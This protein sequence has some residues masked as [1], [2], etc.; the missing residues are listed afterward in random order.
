MRKLNTILA[1][2]NMSAVD[3]EIIKR[4]LLIA[5]ESHAQLHVIHVIDVAVLDIEISSQCLNE[6]VNEEEVKQNILKRV[7]VFD[8]VQKVELLVHVA[9]GKASEALMYTAKKVEADLIIMGAHTKVALEERFFGS[10]AEK[11]AEKSGR[12]VLILK[13]KVIGD[14]QNVLAPTDLSEAS[15]AAVLFAQQLF[16]GSPMKLL[17]AY[18]EID[19]LTLEFTEHLSASKENCFLGRPHTDIFKQKVKCDE[20]VVLKASVSINE[21]LLKYV[22]ADDSDIIVLGSNGLKVLGS[23]VGSTAGFLLTNTTSDVLIYV[24]INRTEGENS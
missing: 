4:A 1:A 23:Y 16:F 11:V 10:T 12:P 5:K 9:K 22:Q 7:A 15:Q 8:D 6:Q 3:D 19:D 2:V 13:N 18:L 17:H 14:Y 20:M 21:S 24:P